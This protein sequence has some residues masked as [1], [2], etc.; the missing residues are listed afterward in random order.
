MIYTSFAS[1][2]AQLKDASLITCHSGT[3]TL[4]LAMF[5]AIEECDDVDGNFRRFEL[6]TSDGFDGYKTLHEFH[7]KD[8]EDVLLSSNGGYALM[9]D[10]EGNAVQVGMCQTVRFTA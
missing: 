7:I 9:Q 2:L 8:N 4:Q 3:N 1:I 6:V 10:I 5:S